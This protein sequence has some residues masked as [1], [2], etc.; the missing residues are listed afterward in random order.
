M[1]DVLTMPPRRKRI[2][3]T[4]F[5]SLGD[6]YP[7]LAMARAL[8][9]LGLEPAIG[10]SAFYRERV[11][12]HGLEFH[13]LRPDTPD[14][15][16]LPQLMGSLMDARHGTEFVIRQIVL[17]ALRESYVDTL[18][19]AAD[20]DLLVSHLLTF[21]TPLVAAQRGIP[22]VSTA[23]QPL[24]LFSTHEP[25]VPPQAPWLAELPF[26]GQGFWRLTRSTFA[27]VSSAWFTPLNELRAELGLPAQATSPIF[28]S[29]SP[30]LTLALFSPLFARPQPDWPAPTLATGFP[31]LQ[32]PGG[33][34]APAL[35]EFLRQ[36]PPPL[37]F[38]LGSS[39]VMT[40]GEF[41]RESVAAA[42][43]LGQRAVFLA[44]QHASRL[45]ETLPPEMFSTDYAPH[46]ALFPRGST[47]VHQGGIGTT[48]EAL[49][50]GK[51]TLIV[52]FAHDQ[53]DNAF[54][55]RRL[56]VSRT[57]FRGRYQAAHVARELIALAHLDVR[58]RAATIGEQIR[59]ERGAAAAAEAIAA[60]LD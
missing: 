1:V 5:G 53:F 48:G 17:P 59:Q 50:A 21:A 55:A 57:L 11:E 35:D 22:W 51:P 29:F 58:Y 15:E 30:W 8:Q 13:P 52:P 9:S 23:L 7:Y 24:T 16:A 33:A 14:P 18:A 26:L 27:R 10:T 39:A 41:F 44:G 2:L 40:P 49:R 34:L 46:S 54:R 56:G 47:I 6:L 38:T 25:A 37:V 4:T 12:A 43:A 36:G 20:I 32:P 42:A 19:A 60:I 28:D 31:F 3:L 45:Q